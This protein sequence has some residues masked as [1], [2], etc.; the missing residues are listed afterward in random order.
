MTKFKDLTAEERLKIEEM[1]VQ[2]SYFTSFTAAERYNLLEPFVQC[3]PE[4]GRI[5]NEY[6]G[7]CYIHKKYDQALR[8]LTNYEQLITNSLKGLENASLI[9]TPDKA[10]QEQKLKE[11]LSYC[12]TNIGLC[13]L[14][15]DSTPERALSFFEKATTYHI[16]VKTYYG[17]ADRLFMSKHYDLAIQQAALGKEHFPSHGIFTKLIAKIEQAKAA[18]SK[19][20][21]TPQAG[22]AKPGN[23]P[24]STFTSGASSSADENNEKIRIENFVNE[25]HFCQFLPLAA[26]LNIVGQIAKK[27]PN[28]HCVQHQ[29]AWLLTKN[30]QYQAA[31]DGFITAE[32]LQN[33]EIETLEQAIKIVPATAALEVQK[34]IT[35][36]KA[37]RS[38]TY[39][40]IGLCYVDMNTK[41]PQEVCSYYEKAYKD[42]PSIK[43]LSNNIYLGAVESI[44][45]GGPGTL[46]AAEQYA[47]TG[48]KLYPSDQRF[49]GLITRIQASK[50]VGRVGQVSH[51]SNS[52][53]INTATLLPSSKPSTSASHSI[54]SSNTPSSNYAAQ[55]PVN[56]ALPS[57]SQA[58]RPEVVTASAKKDASPLEVLSL[59]SHLEREFGN[60]VRTKQADIDQQIGRQKQSNKRKAKQHEAEVESDPTTS[61]V[62]MG[63][64]PKSYVEQVKNSPA[65]HERT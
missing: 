19:A 34:L 49:K 26:R 64:K 41:T 15:L 40:N 61:Q 12:Y 39:S 60:I 50:A 6:A 25:L 63:K 16:N 42:D 4:S 29:Y 46:E 55:Q 33:A 36:A 28:N 32:K 21:E 17:P 11:K 35:A 56:Q 53:S 57:I 13:Y 37:S 9:A 5:Q 30:K 18:S 31:L 44:Q 10:I 3:Y 47:L 27:H 2:I 45:R 59:V 8:H 38:I 23:L 20:E 22:I 65:Q 48:A 51:S 52:S 58:K 1:A 62:S 43:N 24:P 7:S 54:S 14:E